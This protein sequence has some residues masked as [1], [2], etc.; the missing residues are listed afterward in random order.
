MAK[1]FIV[2]GTW[3]YRIMQGRVFSLVISIGISTVYAASL[4]SFIALKSW[5]ALFYV[6]M[7]VVCIGIFYW[8]VY[9]AVK[10][11]V[12]SDISYVA[13]IK[14]ISLLSF[15]VILPMYLWTAFN[16]PI[17]H[18]IDLSSL[19]ATIANAT[20]Q[21]GALCPVTNFFLKAIHELEAIFYY[22]S[23]TSSKTLEQNWIKFLIWSLFFIKSSFVFLAMSRFNAEVILM[24]LKFG[25][26]QQSRQNNDFTDIPT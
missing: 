4:M 8:I 22:Y 5:L 25:H 13:A 23:A 20:A 3:P 19:P 16:T 7:S 17:P 15:L 18:Y 12:A 26:A 10:R 24:I 1:C 9:P 21:T 14:L 2:P 11:W 6:I